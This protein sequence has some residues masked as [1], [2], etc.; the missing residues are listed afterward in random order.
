MRDAFGYSIYFVPYVLLNRFFNEKLKMRDQPIAIVI[1]GAV[2][3]VL[4]WA[5]TNPIGNCSFY[6]DLK[7]L[8]SRLLLKAPLMNGIRRY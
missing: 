8:D 5:L 3:G 1:S 4:S 7:S 6:I 2:A